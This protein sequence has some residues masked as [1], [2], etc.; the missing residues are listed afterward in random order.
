MSTMSRSSTN[1]VCTSTKYKYLI[2]VDY[3][4]KL[5]LKK[6]SLQKPLKIYRV[7]N[8]STY[9]SCTNAVGE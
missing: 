7:C 6:S 4:L 8:Q 9:V 1:S 5:E 2:S 3:L